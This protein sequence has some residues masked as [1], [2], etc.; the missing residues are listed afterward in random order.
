MIDN[1]EFNSDSVWARPFPPL[2]APPPPPPG[3]YKASIDPTIVVADP[4]D[5]TNPNLVVP[6]TDAPPLPPLPIVIVKFSPSTTFIGYSN[7]G[8]PP[9]PP[10]PP[11][12]GN[13][14][15]PLPPPPP[16]PEAVTNIVFTPIGTVYDPLEVNP[17]VLVFVLKC[18]KDELII[19][20]PHK[21][22]REIL[23]DLLELPQ[24]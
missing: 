7:I 3:K 2:A 23:L 4:D 16:P 14:A 13:P 17:I 11:G 15:A 12:R 10:P 18:I 20:T 9:P 21:L 5:P 1:P 6:L 24:S 22:Q 19:L 8:A